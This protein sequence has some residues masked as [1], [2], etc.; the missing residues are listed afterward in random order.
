FVSHN[1]GA[2]RELCQS[3]ICLDQGEVKWTGL[4]P[5]VINSYLAKFDC[6]QSNNE[7]PIINSEYD[8]GFDTCHV[9][10]PEN[11]DGHSFDLKIDITIV[12]GKAYP[13]IGIGF[14]LHTNIG[15]VVSSLGPAVTNYSFSIEKGTTHFVLECPKID[16]LLTAG[17]YTVGLYLSIPN[18][19]KLVKGENVGVIRILVRDFFGSGHHIEAHI[20]GPVLLPLVIRRNYQ[21]EKV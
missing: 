16:R 6:E 3:A 4:A 13:I 15:E 5:Q 14:W 21:G 9:Y 17:Y 20:H 19:I 2:L 18:I 7:F 1:M 10:T 8:I 11:P 12:S